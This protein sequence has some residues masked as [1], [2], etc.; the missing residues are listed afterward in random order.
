MIRELTVALGERSY[1]IYIGEGLLQE[2]ASYFEK[3]GVSK[4]SPLMIVTDQNIG[5]LYLEALEKVLQVA[6][7]QV[8][9]AVVPS[10]EGSKSLAVFEQLVT[11]AL[12]GGLDRKSTIVALGGG[13]V[14][15]LAGYVAASYMRGVR[16]VQ[17]PTTILAHDSSVGGKV[18]VNHPLAKNIIGAF[19]QPAF[20]LYD[21]L[22]LQSLPP[23]DVRSGLSE[24]IK[25]GLIWD[26]AF[27]AW[28]DNNMDKLLALDPEALGYALYK[29]CGVKAAVVSE[30]ETENGLR[31]IL[32]LG[33]TIGHALEAV[34]GYGELTHGEAISI[35]MIG[36]AIVGVKLGAPQEVYEVTRRVLG[37]SGLPV[38]L[39]EHFDTDAVM[40]AMMHDKKF[41]EGSIVYVVPTAIGKVEVRSDVPASLVR[42]T[43]ELL[44]QEADWQ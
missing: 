38:R 40:R 11:K 12:E 3:H 20:V 7:F 37:K 28:C 13:V 41:T 1:P 26:E 15:D 8:V 44:K 23:R 2:A 33:H 16:F 43:V 24:A 10:G 9:S 14:G 17:I 35:G 21:L 34:A 19:H 6:G 22:T 36:S 27:V 5:P 4:R 30:D 31:A 25:H 18:A 42:E 39:P 32:N 29:G